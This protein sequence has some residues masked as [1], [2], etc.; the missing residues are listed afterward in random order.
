[1]RHL[2]LALEG[3]DARIGLEGPP[4]GSCSDVCRLKVA[5]EDK[6]RD[7]KSRGVTYVR[8]ASRQKKV[9]VPGG[10]MDLSNRAE[11]N[12]AFKNILAIGA[13]AVASDPYDPKTNPAGGINLGTAE[14]KLMAD[15][16]V[17]KLNEPGVMEVSARS[18]CYGSYHGS[19][20]LRGAIAATLNRQFKI[21]EEVLTADNV[22]VGNGAGSIV[23][24]ISQILADA[25]DSIIIPSPVYGQ[26]YGD[27]KNVGLVN[28]VFVAGPA[29]EPGIDKLEE[30]FQVAKERG[31]PVKAILITNPG[32]P[33]G[34][35]L[36]CA[37]V[38]SW[39]WW[40]AEKGIHC[41][42]DEVYGMSVW[43]TPGQPEYEE[44]ESVLAMTDLP[45]PL[46]VHVVWS[47]SKDFCMSGMRAGVL[48]SRN[49]RVVAAYITIAYFYAIPQVIEQALTKILSDHEFVDS[50]VVENKIR[51]RNNFERVISALEA[52]SIPFLRPNAAIFIWID[53]RRWAARLEEKSV[54]EPPA[55]SGT[56]QLFQLF[57]DHKVY[58]TPEEAFFGDEGRWFRIIVG[59]PWDVLQVAFSRIF[60]VLEAIDGPSI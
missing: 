38:R 57:L 24:A 11:T 21:E 47:F 12:V 1:M 13:I 10:W 48:V 56:M 40:A 55:P 14:N 43:S 51:L 4:K 3:R 26:F 33:T 34:R 46:S 53:L 8:P 28:P 49:E 45:D 23:S 35:V 30:A 19:P 6:G 42:V 36:S 17:K 52:R 50:F 60:A 59:S 44:F 39:I 22:C 25:G 15:V 2:I 31:S 41:I 16:L 29:S 20:A 5:G 9:I 37:T 54:S 27:L 32:N 58:I 18:L 7:E